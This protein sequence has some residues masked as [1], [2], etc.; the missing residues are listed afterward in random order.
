PLPIDNTAYMVSVL[1]SAM[2]T[3]IMASVLV[4]KY[5]LN[6][7]LAFASAGIGIVISFFSV[8]FWVLLLENLLTNR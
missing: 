8:P 3:M 6:H 1:E 7:N 5:G 4:L 2:P